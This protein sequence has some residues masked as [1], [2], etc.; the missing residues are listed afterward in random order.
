MAEPI[1][2][3]CRVVIMGRIFAT[4]LTSTLIHNGLAMSHAYRVEWWRGTERRIG[5]Y[6]A[7]DVQ[8]GPTVMPYMAVYHER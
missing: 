8:I 2:P 3:G 7:R 4:V 5:W 1:Q 6:H